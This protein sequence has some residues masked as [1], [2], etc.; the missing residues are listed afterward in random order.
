MQVSLLSQFPPTAAGLAA[1]DQAVDQ[2]GYTATGMAAGIPGVVA[3]RRVIAHA[4]A[5]RRTLRTAG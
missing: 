1:L 5:I 3:R 4:E 2:H